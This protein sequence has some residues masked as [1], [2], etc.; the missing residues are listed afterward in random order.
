MHHIF[1]SLKRLH[2]RALAFSRPFCVPPGLTPARYDMLHAIDQHKD[3]LLWQ[4]HLCKILGVTAATISRMAK[5][6]EQLGYITRTRNLFDRRQLDVRITT[7]GRRVFLLV[8]MSAIV[9]GALDFLITCAFAV[10]WYSKNAPADLLRF[11]GFLHCGRRRLFDTS[12][13]YY[14]WHP[15]D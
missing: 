11:E 10:F 8:E 9:S 5:S 13:L 6:L 12:T 3:A 15:D 4:S 2:H 14:P 7:E 1:F